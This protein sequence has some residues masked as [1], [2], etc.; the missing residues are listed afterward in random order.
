MV[1][2]HQKKKNKFMVFDENVNELEIG[3][4]RVLSGLALW[5]IME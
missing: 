1:E 4:R 3:N 5:L 2:I